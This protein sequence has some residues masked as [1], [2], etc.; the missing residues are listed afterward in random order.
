MSVLLKILVVR[1]SD[2]CN[3]NSSKIISVTDA[4]VSPSYVSQGFNLQVTKHWPI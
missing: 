4:G 3:L 1:Y 2:N